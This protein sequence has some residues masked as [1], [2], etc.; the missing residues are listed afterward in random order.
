MP[1]ANVPELRARMDAFARA[2]LTLADFEPV[3]EVEW[4]LELDEVTPALFRALSLLE[5]YGAGNHEPVFSARG[6]KLLAPPRIL[7]DKH[8]KLK[9]TAGAIPA[10]GAGTTSAAAR[11]AGLMRA[12]QM[13]Q[14]RKCPKRR[15]WFHPAAI[16]MPP[17]PARRD[18]RAAVAESDGATVPLVAK[19]R[20]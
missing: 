15:F 5:P 19:I 4:E 9:L 17:H 7:K 1:S 11:V 6:V 8:I 18:V 16:P 14:A 10:G 13:T 12:R 3:L 20:I 2:R